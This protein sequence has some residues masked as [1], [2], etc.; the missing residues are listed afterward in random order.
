MPS[1]PSPRYGRRWYNGI[2]RARGPYRRAPG[3]SPM[4]TKTIARTRE[5][6]SPDRFPDFPPRDDMQNWLYIYEP[7]IT[8]A[9]TAHLERRFRTR[10][11]TVA[12]EVPVSPRL[13]PRDD[14]RIPDLMVTF[15]CDRD[16]LEEQRGYDIE[17]Q[18]KPPEF[19]LEVA[20]VT[21]GVVDY[22]RKRAD[23]ERYG[24]Y[25]YLRFDPSGGRYH[26]APLAGDRLVDG[27]YEPIPVETL[28]D[29]T[30][31]CYS[32]VLGL[33][34]CWESGRLRFFDPMDESYL[35]THTE[36]IARA[37][38]EASGRQAAEARAEREEARADMEASGR[39]TAETRADME[40]SGRQAAEA[41]IAELEAE[42][43]RLRGD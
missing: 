2:Q 32:E 31:R 42:L 7:A 33:Y 35:R 5:A 43:R 8:T 30:I 20:S 38:A 36:D 10:K 39:Q 3:V 22:T 34:L 40:A 23:Y 11:A 37:E 16:L 9:L 14:L 17:R 26:D 4:T 28:S 18:G 29:G 12:N 41:R 24:V 13:R 21:T 6:E 25:E 15:D 27:R 1:H 19:V